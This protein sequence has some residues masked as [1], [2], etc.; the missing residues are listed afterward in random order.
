[1]ESRAYKYRIK[2]SRIQD[3]PCLERLGGGNF[4]GSLIVWKKQD[5]IL[6]TCKTCIFRDGS[7]LV[8]II[9]ELHRLVE[10][11]GDRIPKSYKKMNPKLEHVIR[12]TFNAANFIRDVGYEL[13]EIKEGYCETILQ[14]K[15]KHLQ[16]DGFIHAGVLATMA[17]HTAGTAGGTVVKPGQIVLTAEYKINIL[18]PAVGK[19]L[20][21]QALVIK[22][23]KVLVVV[24][25]EVYAINKEGKKLVAKALVTLA[26]VAKENL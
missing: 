12:N 25:S 5:S 17:D 10:R 18:R 4:T 20:L 8:S 26:V 6:Q 19:M 7:L 23:G 24:D 9:G 3:F 22:P 2:V 15:D 14:I 11:K 1:M 13:K 16:Q 21:C